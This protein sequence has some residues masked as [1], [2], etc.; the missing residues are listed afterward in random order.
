VPEM[1]EHAG[2]P[3]ADA[4]LCENRPQGV[5]RPWAAGF[6]NPVRPLSRRMGP[7]VCLAA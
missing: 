5:I 1:Q 6:G 3:S 7:I 4:V 2:Q